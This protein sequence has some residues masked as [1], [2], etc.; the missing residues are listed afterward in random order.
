MAAGFTHRV[1]ITI[2]GKQIDGWTSY[3]ISAS[4]R[5]AV[6]HFSLA[7]PF[8]PA[9]YRLLG[10]DV[11]VAIKI[12]DVFVIVG[13]IDKVHKTSARGESTITIEGRDKVGR[14][15]Q[16]SAPTIAYDGI[17][18]VAVATQLAAPWFGKV[19]LSGARDRIV[20]LGK[21]GRHAAAGNEALV[22]KV[23][24]KTWQHEPGQSRFKIINDLA[25]EAG[26]M[27]W[28]SCDGKELIIGVP[29]QT[30]GAQYL[31]TNPGNDSDLFPTAMTLAFEDSI[32]DSF[33][34]IMALGSGRGDAANYGAS[35]VSRRDIV[36]D[37]TAIDGTGH[38]FI[39][40]KRLIMADRTLLNPEEAH[41][42]AL[43][44]M[45]R[46]DFNKHKVTATMPGHGQ[47]T[48]GTSPT[49][50]APNT[51]AR[52]V[53]DEQD[54]PIDAAYIVYECRYRGS[55]DAGETTDLS[56]VPRGTV[57]VQ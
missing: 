23:K 39:R 25:S 36:R 9:T 10:T 17:D 1:S 7:R 47:I 56:L 42:H 34:L 40:P 45:N 31:I 53:D 46:R 20:R 8:D 35:T 18:F 5:E 32:T 26:Y 14:L 49:L 43:R 57:F 4:M 37:G 51:I 41:Q 16:E 2:G 11:E 30:Q 55:R 21:R 29:N 13:Y 44:E 50:F 19:S 52:V 12:D 28:S 27:V 22:V 24:K 48:G 38:D 15:V 3:E 54:L 33:S 6:D